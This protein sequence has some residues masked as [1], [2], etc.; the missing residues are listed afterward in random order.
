MYIV[1]NVRNDPKF[2]RKGNDLTCDVAVRLTQACLGSEITMETLGGKL[3]R[4]P[5]K[6]GMQSGEVLSLKGLGIPDSFGGARG[7]LH[8]KINIK[9]PKNLTKK[10]KSLLI[11]LEKSLK[12]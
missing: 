7:N 11:E 8:V 6:P 1:V 4:I 9:I 10:Q 3:V 12:S 2:T 5:L